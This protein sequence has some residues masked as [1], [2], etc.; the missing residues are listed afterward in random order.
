LYDAQHR[1][2]FGE[3]RNPGARLLSGISEA[4]TRRACRRTARASQCVIAPASSCGEYIRAAYSLPSERVRVIPYGLSET[5]RTLASAAHE[6]G[7][8]MLFV[9]N[10]LPRKGSFVLESVLPPLAAQ[11]P[12]ASLTFVADAA[13]GPQLDRQYRGTFGPRLQVHGWMPRDD[14][15]ALYSTHDILLFPSLF[16]GFGKVWMEAMAA[17]LCVVGFSEGGLPDV[18]REGEALMCP[19]GD[20]A[21]LARNVRRSLENP[22]WAA[23]IG[24]RGGARVQAFSWERAA[25]ETIELCR[26]LGAPSPGPMP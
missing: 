21:G 4:L 14:L 12:D 26:R 23:E 15:N 19:A 2:G 9:G 3:A 16:E 17:G 24:R 11:F 25:Q 7:R 6:P 22:R 18:A 5:T 1:L 20:V 10:Y 13:A 8:R